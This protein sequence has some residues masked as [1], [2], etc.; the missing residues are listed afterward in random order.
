MQFFVDLLFFLCLFIQYSFSNHTLCT[1]QISQITVPFLQPLVIPLENTPHD[2]ALLCIIEYRIDYD[3]KLIYIN[4]KA[5]N[6]TKLLP[7]EYHS[8][9]L[10]QSIWLAF[11]GE[12]QQP[13]ITHRKYGCNT[14]TDCGRAFYLN[15]IERLITNGQEKLDE[16]K[17]NLYNQSITKRRCRDSTLRG[18]QS[19]VRCGYGLCYAYSIDKKQSCT[20]SDNSPTFFS[21]IEYHRPKSSGNERESIEYKCNTD[22]CNGNRMMKIIKDLLI[23]YT[24]WENNLNSPTEGN[25]IEEKSSNNART[26]STTCLLIF[27]FIYLQFLF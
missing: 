19:I 15:T 3:A 16:I 5:S 8:E 1:S 20:S 25:L 21:E 10:I 4:F 7:V 13:N 6:D 17:S 24:S 14:Q 11:N 9:F 2:S 18:N 26:L 23:D 22:F 12:T 27:S